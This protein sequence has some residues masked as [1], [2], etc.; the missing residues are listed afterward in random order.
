MNTSNNETRELAAEL[1]S[2]A[3]DKASDAAIALSALGMAYAAS[4]RG[5]GVP[6]EVFSVL[7]DQIAEVIYSQPA[8]PSH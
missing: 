2:L 6:L 5:A 7:S 4:S 8:P 3:L 1:V